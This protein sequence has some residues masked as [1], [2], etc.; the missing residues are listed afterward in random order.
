MLT[1]RRSGVTHFDS[2]WCCAPNDKKVVLYCI[3]GT[4]TER[5]LDAL[6]YRPAEVS[7]ANISNEINMR[8]HWPFNLTG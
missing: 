2:T 1:Q 5:S 4:G 8:G 3:L 6:I 7:M